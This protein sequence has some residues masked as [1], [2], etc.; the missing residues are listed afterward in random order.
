MGTLRLS[1]FMARCG[2]ASRR[3]AEEIITSGKVK[4]NN[5][6]VLEP[7][8]QVTEDKDVVTYENQ[9]INDNIAKLYIALYK[10]VKVLS[11][12]KH[13]DDRTIARSLLPI[14]GRLFPVGRLDYHS[15]GLM[16]FTNDGEFANHVAHPRFEVEKEYVVKMKGLLNRSEMKQMKEG[17]LIDGSV[18]KVEDVSYV[19][20][21]LQNTWYRIVVREGKNRMLRKI[22]EK[23]GHHVLKLKRVRIGNITLGRMK[24]GEYRYLEDYE[25]KE[26]RKAFLS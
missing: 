15:E 16:L 22:G 25:V 4:V 14:E 24:P 9:I 6:I 5:I 1:V 19:K 2:I 7:Q 23:L 8:F 17:L 18:H 3:K 12:L 26:A 10:P 11:D 13:D 21:S 20:A